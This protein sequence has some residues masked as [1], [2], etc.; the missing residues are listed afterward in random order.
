MTPKEF[1]RTYSRFAKESE[2]KTKVPYLFTL[3]QAALESGWGGKVKGNNFFG[4]KDTDGINGNEQEFLT[5]EFNKGKWIKIKQW[6]RKYKTP[7]E[8]F[9]DQGKFLRT[10]KRY[11]NAFSFTDPFLFSREVAK[12]GYATDPKYYEKIAT[13]LRILQRN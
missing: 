9:T 3:A 12:A 1:Y 2:L 8:S 4:I 7:E 6:F 13:I 11:R 5:T 10:N